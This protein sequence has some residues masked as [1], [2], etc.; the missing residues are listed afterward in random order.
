MDDSAVQAE[1]RKGLPAL[2]SKYQLEQ[3]LDLAQLS[4]IRQ[5]ENFGW[6]LE[7]VRRYGLPS[8][9][10]LLKSYSTNKWMAVEA[11][12]GVIENPSISIR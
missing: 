4:I 12:G 7:I 11:G 10:A 2:P 9:L 5:L 1:R 3:Y 6:G 8:P